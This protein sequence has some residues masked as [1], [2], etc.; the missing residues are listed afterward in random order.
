MWARLDDV[1]RNF[2]GSIDFD[3][4]RRRAARIRTR[5]IREFFTARIRPLAKPAI[6]V[7]IL[8]AALL[9]MPRDEAAFESTRQPGSYPAVAVEA[10]DPVGEFR[11][12]AADLL[13]ATGPQ[14][15]GDRRYMRE[16]HP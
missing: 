15:D 5:A 13:T 2:D 6:A 8:V 7:G 4:Y 16:V 10:K 1:R 12:F 11:R 9:S 14:R 3:F